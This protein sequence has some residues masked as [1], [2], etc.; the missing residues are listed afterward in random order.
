M[1]CFHSGP[2]LNNAYSCSDLTLNHPMIQME[3]PVPGHSRPKRGLSR[4]AAAGPGPGSRQRRG[5]HGHGSLRPATPAG[6]APTG[7][8]TQPAFPEPADARG[9]PDETRYRARRTG[10]AFQK[11]RI[12]GNHLC[13]RRFRAVRPYPYWLRGKAARKHE[14]NCSYQEG[15][16]REICPDSNPVK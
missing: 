9:P 16:F 6:L 14:R 7:S 4:R 2:G 11:Q 8:P 5:T 13:L 1:T 3:R 15:S 12:Y 10:D